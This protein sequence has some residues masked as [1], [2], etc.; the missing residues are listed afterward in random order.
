MRKAVPT[1]ITVVTTRV[2]HQNWSSNTRGAVTYG[3]NRQT[4]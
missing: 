3:H 4:T 1:Q 2:T